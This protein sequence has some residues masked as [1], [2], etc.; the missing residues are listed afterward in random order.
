[1]E[2]VA[3]L[4]GTRHELAAIEVE[5]P[6]EAERT[7]PANDV[8]EAEADGGPQ[9]RQIDLAGAAIDAA[10]IEEAHGL[11]GTADA[12]AQL[13]VQNDD[14]VA[15]DREPGRADRFRRR[16]AIERE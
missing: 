11:N 8:A 14:A 1:M 6:V 9:L 16:Q 7:E 15:A 10:R 4:A 3:A 5:A 13:A 12:H 2:D